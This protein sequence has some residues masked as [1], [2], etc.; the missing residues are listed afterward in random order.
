MA[1]HASAK[2]RIRTNVRRHQVNRSRLSRI[3]TMVRAV[4]E[5]IASGDRGAAMKAFSAAQSDLMRG[6][7]RGILSA[8]TVARRISRLNA[9]IR[10]L[11]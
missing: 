10:A 5:A 7:Q 9:R 3:R 8:R 4:E 2:K 1:H 11:A 6:S